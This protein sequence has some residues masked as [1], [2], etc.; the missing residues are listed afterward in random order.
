M[1]EG[2]REHVREGG[3]E[4]TCCNIVIFLCMRLLYTTEKPPVFRETDS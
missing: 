3:R 2:G 1:R 4:G